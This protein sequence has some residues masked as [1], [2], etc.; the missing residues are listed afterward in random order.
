MFF[1]DV[2]EITILETG[3]FI[4]LV[5]EDDEVFTVMLSKLKARKLYEMLYDI[6]DRFSTSG[7]EV[8]WI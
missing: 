8:I 3:V 7:S 5:A 6:S 2:R 4:D 1:K